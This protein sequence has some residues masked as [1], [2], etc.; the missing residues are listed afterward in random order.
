MDIIKKLPR[1]SP[2]LTANYKL[3]RIEWT[4]K[5]LNNDWNNTLFSDETAFQLFQNTLEQI[6]DL[7]GNDWQFQHDNDP[8]HTS[9][10][11]KN[12]IHDNMPEVID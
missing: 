11:A 5:H 4:K 3:K 9:C 10:L 2:I 7:L 6:E 12:F 1:A 8:K